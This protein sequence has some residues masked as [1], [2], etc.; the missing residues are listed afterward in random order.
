MSCATK[1]T[2]DGGWRIVRRKSMGDVS[3][4]IAMAMVIHF[5]TKPRQTA[6]I[7]EI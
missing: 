4:A 2:S 6:R 7:I 1:P 5:A 3:A